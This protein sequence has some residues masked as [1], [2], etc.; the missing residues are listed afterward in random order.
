MQIFP[1]AAGGVVLGM[2]AGRV[3]GTLALEQK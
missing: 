1:Y 3:T 2:G